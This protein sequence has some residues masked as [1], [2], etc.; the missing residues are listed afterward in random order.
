MHLVGLGALCDLS[1]SGNDPRRSSFTVSE[2]AVLDDGE[3]MRLHNERGF[4]VVS[5][6]GDVWAPETVERLT[7]QVLA[8]VLPDE[9]EPEEQHPWEWLAELLRARG[10]DATINDLR[11]L[12]YE[13]VFTER[14]LQR[15]P[16]TKEWR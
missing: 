12:P 13:V 6:T 4:N 3:R 15:L 8:T 14:V 11:Q 1:P 10:I 16:T 9:D 7:R 5:L 2:F